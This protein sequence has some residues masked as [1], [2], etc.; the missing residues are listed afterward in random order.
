MI[1]ACDDAP[2][3]DED[4]IQV[5]IT[6]NPLTVETRQMPPPHLVYKGGAVQANPAKGKWVKKETFLRPA[7]IKKWAMY[8]IPHGGEQF[9]RRTRFDHAKLVAFAKLF[10]ERCRACGMS[11]PAPADMKPI[12]GNFEQMEDV[13]KACKQEKCDFVFFVTSDAITNLHSFMKHC[14]QRFGIVSQD[15]KMSNADE[16]L[17]RGKQET[18]SNIIAKTNVKLGGQ[19][20]TITAADPMIKTMINE[21]TLF[22]GLGTS[23]PGAMGSYERARGA[24]PSIPSVIGYSANLKASGF[25]EF[26]LH[27]VL[28]ADHVVLCG[29]FRHSSTVDEAEVAGAKA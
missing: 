3:P 29:R 24:T 4:D 19:N 6:Q 26:P 27:L 22:I 12:F 10:T 5:L 7:E 18:L 16:I 23:H 13:F 25:V 21:G 17:S 11:V 28:R 9:D 1:R 14:E 20:Y 8:M 2:L 15:L